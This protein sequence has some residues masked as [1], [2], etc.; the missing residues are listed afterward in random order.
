MSRQVGVV[1]SLIWLALP[2]LWLMP[3]QT[4]LFLGSRGNCC[5]TASLKQRNQLSKE[6]W[7]LGTVP[8]L[9]AVGGTALCLPCSLSPPFSTPVF[10]FVSTEPLVIVWCSISINPAQPVALAD[11]T[12]SL[13]E[14]QRSV[15]FSFL[16]LSVS[17]RGFPSGKNSLGVEKKKRWHEIFKW[18]AVRSFAL[19]Y[20]TSKFCSSKKLVCLNGRTGLK[21]EVLVL[22]ILAWGRLGG[23]QWPPPW[24]ASCIPISL[25]GGWSSDLLSL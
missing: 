14:C 24:W 12:A 21:K 3:G 5:K 18:T 22:G 7:R 20:K 19:C 13:L 17:L 4:H 10:K 6:G 25:Q 2:L 11:S 9:P 8:G 23:E 15:S 1:L 16:I